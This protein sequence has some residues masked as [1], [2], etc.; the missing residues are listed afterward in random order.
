MMKRYILLRF[1]QL[2]PILFGI[3]FVSFLLIRGTA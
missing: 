2:I 1:M 3:T